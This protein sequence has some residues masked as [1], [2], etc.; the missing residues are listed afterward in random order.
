MSSIKLV[1]TIFKLLVKPL[2]NRIKL[3]EGGLLV[4]NV[5]HSVVSRKSFDLIILETFISFLVL[6]VLYGFNDYTDVEKD[7]LNP[8]KAPTFINLALENYHLFL[9]I[10][11]T[12]QLL[13]IALGLVFFSWKIAICLIILYAVNF[14]YSY[15]VKSIPLADII[16]VSIWGGLYV[17]I[18]GIFHWEISLA[19]GLMV[20]IAHFFQVITDK[21]SDEKSVVRTSAVVLSGW[22][23]LLLFTLCFAFAMVLYF[24]TNLLWMI[25]IGFLPFFFYILSG[26]R[27]AFSWNLSR[28]LFFILWLVIL[29]KVYAGI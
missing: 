9:V 7:K 6:C 3:G 21:D 26:H 10:I 8:K 12:V 28:F 29:K 1:S 20:G 25:G 27:V 15:R 2:T 4:L 23:N 5:T 16:I 22:Q 24:V 19:A 14:V 18:T 11:I 17:C 13:T